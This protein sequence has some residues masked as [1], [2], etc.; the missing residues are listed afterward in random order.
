MILEDLNKKE[1]LSISSTEEKDTDENKLEQKTK[2]NNDKISLIHV[3][4]K[5]ENNFELIGSK[6]YQ[7][8]P[9]ATNT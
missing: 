2:E 7:S 9:A 6:I 5:N 3:E 4:E 1:L 8:A